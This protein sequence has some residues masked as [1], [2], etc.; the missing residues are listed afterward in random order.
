MNHDRVSRFSP[1]IMSTAV[2]EVT[3]TDQLRYYAYAIPLVPSCGCAVT[4]VAVENCD[5]G[6]CAL[7]G[8]KL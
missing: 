3:S 7:L 4:G 6:R 2:D 1:N 5:D 8:S